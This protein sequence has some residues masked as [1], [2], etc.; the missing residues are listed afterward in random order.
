MKLK[1][2]AAA[3]LG[4]AM[5]AAASGC[6]F[7]DFGREDM[8]RPPKT[9]GDEA[10]IEKLIAEN[11]PGG[12]TLKYPKSGA[13]RS[14]IV[15]HDLDGDDAEEAIAFFRD[16]NSSSGVHML[17]MYEEKSVWKTSDDFFT[18]TTD[19][20]CVDF[21]DVNADGAQELLVGYATYT[22]G[23]NILS[24]YT[25]SD[26][27]TKTIQSGQNYSAFYCGNLDSSGK[28]KV[29]TLSLF[30]PENEAKAT[31]LEYDSKQAALTEKAAAALDPNIVSYKNVLFSELSDNTK[32]LVVDGELASGELNTQVIYYNKQLKAL[33]NPLYAEKTGNPTQRS[34]NVYSADVG[35]DMKVEV[36]TVSTL[37]YS[38][39][40]GAF[41]AADQ[42]VWNRFSPSQEALIPLQRTAANYNYNYTI[43]I[44]EAWESGLFTVLLNEDGDEMRFR[45]WSGGKAG[46]EVFV[47]RV[48]K[49]ADWDQGKDVE[50]YSLINK[51]NRFAYTFRNHKTESAL[52]ISD[53]EI[54]TAF[55]LISGTSAANNSKN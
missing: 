54:K 8:L 30:S 20:D 12:Y 6:D 29:I 10:E 9:M 15:M 3:L 55:S 50:G 47:I 52:A 2:V 40:S 13:N 39:Q 31:L 43:K 27:S 14:A 53:D 36:P 23:V 32:G 51:D 24:A 5:L 34:S 44:P 1:P 17:V 21:A 22:S 49:I 11:A 18:E 33:R 7:S 41:T 38:A 26:G 48:F 46:A 35:N 19:V 16:K 45:E 42:V 4:A 37:P 28:S 25:F